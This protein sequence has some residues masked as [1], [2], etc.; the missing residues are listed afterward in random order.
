MCGDAQGDNGV[1]DGGAKALL[2]VGVPRGVAEGGSL[3]C[4]VGGGVSHGVEKQ[5]FVVDDG[6][7][8][9]VGLY[10]L[11]GGSKKAIRMAVQQSAEVR[12]GGG[13]DGG[14]VSSR[15]VDGVDGRG[16]VG[17]KWSWGAV[18]TE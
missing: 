14:R 10:L 8:V 15:G 5:R 12:R 17:D 16:V 4:D 9:D 13:G 7:G 6:A 11:H 3:G 18:A 2:R 1:I